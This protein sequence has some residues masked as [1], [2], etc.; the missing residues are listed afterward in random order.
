MFIYNVYTYVLQRSCTR[1]CA[2]ARSGIEMCPI[3]RSSSYI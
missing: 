2:R 3:A 1:A